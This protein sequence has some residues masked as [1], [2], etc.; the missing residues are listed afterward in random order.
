MKKACLPFCAAQRQTNPPCQRFTAPLT[1]A[2]THTHT[3]YTQTKNS[4]LLPT[5]QQRA[6][7]R[8]TSINKHT[9]IYTSSEKTHK[10][11]IHNCPAPTVRHLIFFNFK[12]VMTNQFIHPSIFTSIDPILQLHIILLCLLFW[13]R[14]YFHS[15][16]EFF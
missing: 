5:T 14:P 6:L 9:Y 10:T 1:H 7:S 2:R 3:S 16:S 15:L 13:L 11:Y 8:P 4:L 12:Y